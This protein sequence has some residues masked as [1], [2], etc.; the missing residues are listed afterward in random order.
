MVWPALMPLGCRHRWPRQ[1]LLWISVEAQGFR[2]SGRPANA[3]SLALTA[4]LYSEAVGLSHLPGGGPSCSKT[5]CLLQ[6]R[7][8]PL[9]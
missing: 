2:V 7:M 1:H 8:A 3:T 6:G 5:L 9:T 4:H